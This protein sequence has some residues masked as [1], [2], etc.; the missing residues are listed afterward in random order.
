VQTSARLDDHRCPANEAVDAL[1]SF[2]WYCTQ[3]LV[4]S[5]GPRS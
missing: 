2:A 4:F 3:G 5:A 1:I